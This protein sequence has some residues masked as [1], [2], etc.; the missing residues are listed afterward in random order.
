LITTETLKVGVETKG[1]LTLGETV[2]D[3]REHFRWEHL[4]SIDAA[5]DID[6][7]RFF[8]LLLRSIA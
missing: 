5:S 1:E 7:Q 2:V 8:D 3:R 4:P 6:E